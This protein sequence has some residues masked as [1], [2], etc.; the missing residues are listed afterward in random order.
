MYK[1]RAKNK[2]KCGKVTCINEI[3]VEMSGV[4]RGDRGRID[5]LNMELCVW[6]DKY[7]I[8]GK[9]AMIVTPT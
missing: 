4:L 2:H 3:R 8:R 9:K 6:T 1:K 7:Q 5:G